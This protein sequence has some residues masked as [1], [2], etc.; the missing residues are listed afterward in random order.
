MDA[1]ENVVGY[2]GIKEELSKVIDMFNN[3]K[4]YESMG[5][6]LTKG[7]LLFGEPGLGKTLLAKDL[8]KACNVKSFVIVNDKKRSDLIYDINRVFKEAI[9]SEKAIILLDDIDKFGCKSYDDEPDSVFA[10]IQSNIDKIKTNNVLIIATANNLDKLPYSLIRKGRFDITIDVENPNESDCEKIVEYYLKT[11]KVNKDFNYDDAY[12]IV[13]YTSCADLESFLNEAAILAA[14]KRKD[15]IDIKDIIDV[16]TKENYSVKN[17]DVKCSNEELYATS[18]HEAGHA[19]V[20]EALH[21]GCVGFVSVS[22]Y[23]SKSTQGFTKLGEQLVRR[24]ENILF[25]LGGKA[26][27]ELFYQGRCASGCQFDLNTA[28]NLVRGGI[29]GSGTLGIGNAIQF[30]IDGM[31]ESIKERIEYLTQSEI[32]RNMFI[33]KDILLKN[34][35]LLLKIAD[36]LSK[37]CYLLHSDIKRIEQEI[38]V[39]HYDV[40]N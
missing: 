22:K 29:V 39:I 10:N 33:V 21:K 31:S 40:A 12:K 19:V 24:P 23:K 11:K 35:D 13:G 36:E 6:K 26:A 34:K 27:C 3:Q 15:S 20:A 9:A 14:Y 8:I 7:I 5:A 25:T 38:D 2:D 37:K 30:K 17:C 18:L 4:V 28:F 32:E 1:F 16:Y